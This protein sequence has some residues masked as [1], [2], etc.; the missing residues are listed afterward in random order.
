M[1]RATALAWRWRRNSLRRRTDVLESWVGLVAVVLMLLAGPVSG[2]VTGSLAHEALRH[3]VR[4]QH[5]H[6]HLVTATTLRALRGGP[7]ETDR[8]A[9]AAAREGHHRVVARW[10]G[11]DGKER[12][13]VVPVRHATRPGQPFP[14]WTDDQGRLSGRPMDHDTAAVHAGLAGA[15]AA[16]VAC[17]LLEAVRRLVVW[18]VM[19]RR[20]A[21]WDR[22]WLRAG[23]TW[24]RAD[25]GS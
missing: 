20:Y 6:R 1:M 23:Q 10:P 11:P 19:Q 17:G 18:R 8:E 16:A 7:A 24:G 21:R 9:T 22:A 15:G 13:G 3:T 14:L 25:A 5:R 12:S 2:W 4:E